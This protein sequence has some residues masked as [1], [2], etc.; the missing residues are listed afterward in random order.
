MIK[1]NHNLSKKRYSTKASTE[2]NQMLELFDKN[3]KTTIIKK[4][5]QLIINFPETNGKIGSLSKD[6]AIIFLKKHKETIELKKY[7]NRNFSKSLDRLIQTQREKTGKKIIEV[8]NKKIE[9]TQS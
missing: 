3:F 9:V 6:S 4:F 2:M 1:E 8:D 7:S 5:Q